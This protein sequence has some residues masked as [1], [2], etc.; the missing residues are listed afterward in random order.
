M[1]VLLVMIELMIEDVLPENSNIHSLSLFFGRKGHSV[2]IRFLTEHSVL[3][4]ERTLGSYSLLS[5][6]TVRDSLALITTTT[7]IVMIMVYY[8]HE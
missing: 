6:S 3:R 1:C 4:K 7:G 5:Q 8:Q 2:P